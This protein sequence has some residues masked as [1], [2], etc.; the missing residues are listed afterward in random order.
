MPRYFDKYFA[1]NNLLIINQFSK[2]LIKKNVLIGNFLINYFGFGLPFSHKNYL[3][4]LLEL[5]L[6][7]A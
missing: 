2:T 3:C 1:F 5:A 7:G 6:I 4:Y